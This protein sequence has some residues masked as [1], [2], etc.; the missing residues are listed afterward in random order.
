VRDGGDAGVTEPL[1]QQAVATLSKRVYRM[2]HFLWHELRDHWLTYT[3]EARTRIRELGWEPPRPAA[4]ERAVEI[5]ANDSGVDFFYLHC[6][7][8]GFINWILAELGDATFPR[9]EGWAAMPGPDDPDFPV[10]PAWFSPEYLPVS[11]AFIARSKTDDFF[12]RRFRYWE[13]L[14]TDAAFLKQLSLGELGTAVEATLHDAV[15]SRWAA[16]PAAVRPDPPAP[17]EPIYDGWDEPRYDFLR[18]PYA[19]HVNPIYWK[20]YGWVADRVEDWKIANGVSGRDFWTATWVGKMPPE[21][22]PSGRCP[23]N[24]RE[25]PPL[26]AVFEDDDIAAAHVTEME[27]VVAI[28]AETEATNL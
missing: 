12:E 22:E 28:I 23:P 16:P 5:V 9:I 18:D 8:N 20:F 2:H 11:N 25:G 7:L 4:D 15:R 1:P 6:E 19:M 27:Q 10:P 21:H 3:E 26:F 13:R 14:C 24:F 17:G